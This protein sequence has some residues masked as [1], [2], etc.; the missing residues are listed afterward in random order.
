MRASAFAGG[1]RQ[2]GLWGGEFQLVVLE[3]FPDAPG[4]GGADALVDRE[5][6]PQV[7]GGL[8][9]VA[10]LEVAVADSFQG[11]CFLWGRADVAGDGQRPGVL[12]AGLAGGRGAERELAEAVQRFGLAEPVAEVTEQRQGLLVAGGGGR[13]V[14]GLL[15]HEAE[16]VEGVGLAEPVTEVAEQRQGL[17]LAGGGGRVVPGLLLHDA[18]VVEGV[19]LAVQVAEVAEQR[20]GLLLAGGGGRVVPGQLLHAGPG[21]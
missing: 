1:S 6:L 2:L 15:L 17:L 4:G 5:C 7:R 11:A 16:V 8:A 20:Q 12:V 3:G 14:P 18:E 9:G 13:V 10:V 19:G 21:C